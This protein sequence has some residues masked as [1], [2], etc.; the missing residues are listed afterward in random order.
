MKAQN[1]L[2][3]SNTKIIKMIE[4]KITKKNNKNLGLPPKKCFFNVV[5]VS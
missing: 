2:D 1:L 5:D 4:T 3:Q